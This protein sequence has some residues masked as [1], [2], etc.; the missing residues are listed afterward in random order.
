MPSSVY[1]SIIV[2][3]SAGVFLTVFLVEPSKIRRNDGR[4][5]AHFR[6]LRWIEELKALPKS[7]LTPK[8]LLLAVGLFSCQMSA[9]FS[10]SLNAFYFNARTRA[11]INVGTSHSRATEAVWLT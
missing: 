10:G 1:I 9:S 8:T 3:Q 5:I 4:P 6:S 7:L 2:I 11:L